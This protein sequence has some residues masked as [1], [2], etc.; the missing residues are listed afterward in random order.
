MW[1]YKLGCFLVVLA[2]VPVFAGERDLSL[3]NAMIHVESQG[4]PAAQGTHGEVGIL[5]IK[6]QMVR[7]VNRILGE[8]RFT[9]R[10]RYSPAKSVEIFWIYTD[11]YSPG[12]RRETIAR[13]WNGGPTGEKNRTTTRY[14]GKIR[15]ALIRSP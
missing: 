10:D 15:A 8:N 5:Q 13:R 6:P 3:L 12:A 1:K 7:D 2:A 11:Y 9:L 4:N 14:W